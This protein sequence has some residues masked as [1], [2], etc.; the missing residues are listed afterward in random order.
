M[1]ASAQEQYIGSA[2]EHSL[3]EG[4]FGRWNRRFLL[5]FI[6]GAIFIMIIPAF[7]G[8]DLII[9]NTSNGSFL[10]FN[11]T[12][13][14]Y[15]VFTNAILRDPEVYGWMSIVVQFFFGVKLAK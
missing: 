13:T 9:P 5:L 3:K 15:K 10:G 11:W 4:G 1:K 2:R 7:F 6:S 12:D 14:E 8:I